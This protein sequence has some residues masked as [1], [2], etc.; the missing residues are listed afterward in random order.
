M[1]SSLYT[2]HQLS[3][4]VERGRLALIIVV[5]VFAIVFFFFSSNIILAKIKILTGWWLKP[6]PVYTEWSL[7]LFYLIFFSDGGKNESRA[8]RVWMRSRTVSVFWDWLFRNKG[9]FS[10]SGDFL[11]FIIVVMLSFCICYF[12]HHSFCSHLLLLL[13]LALTNCNVWTLQFAF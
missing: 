5:W 1:S 12:N 3:S 9:T 7:F 13:L 8:R 4:L 6:R 2:V 11:S 10:I